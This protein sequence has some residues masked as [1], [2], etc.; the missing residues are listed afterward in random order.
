MEK[1]GEIKQAL[2]QSS[3]FYSQQAICGRKIALGANNLLAVGSELSIPAVGLALC[4]K[5]QDH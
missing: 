5:G 2:S 3:Q 1:A 4:Y